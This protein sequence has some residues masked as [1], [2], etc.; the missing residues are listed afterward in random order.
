MEQ[1]E[2]YRATVIG[3]AQG[4][5]ARFLSILT[6]YNKAPGVL[7]ERMYIETLQQMFS[8]SSKVLIDTKSSNNMLYLPLDKIMQ[9]SSRDPAVSRTNPMT[10]PAAVPSP[11]NRVDRP[12]GVVPMSNTLSRDRNAR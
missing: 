11:S 12:S 4:D 5:T 9:Q 6:Q 3:D 1:A 2:G 10:P 8:Q 7:R